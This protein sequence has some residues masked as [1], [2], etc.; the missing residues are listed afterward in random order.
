MVAVAAAG[1]VRAMGCAVRWSGG[2]LVL[3]PAS[4]Y[5]AWWRWRRLVVEAV[6][7]GEAAEQHM[8]RLRSQAFA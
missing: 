8:M 7:S 1:L 6:W 4:R 2:S 5:S 3:F